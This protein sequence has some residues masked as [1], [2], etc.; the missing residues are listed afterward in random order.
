MSR[1]PDFQMFISWP[2]SVFLSFPSLF[3]FFSFHLIRK[4]LLLIPSSCS[5]CCLLNSCSPHGILPTYPLYMT[6]YIALF[7]IL[8]IVYYTSYILH[9]ISYIVYLT[10]YILHRISYIAHHNNSLPFFNKKKRKKKKSPNLC[11]SVVPLRC[12]ITLS[13]CKVYT[14][15]PIARDI[16]MAH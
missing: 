4:H 5:V 8:Y 10:S 1:F 7:C 14:I 6:H 3:L 13:L 2:N 15:L 9:C 12:V 16:H 11:S